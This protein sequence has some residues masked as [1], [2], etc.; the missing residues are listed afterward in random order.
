MSGSAGLELTSLPLEERNRVFYSSGTTEQ[1]RSR[2]FHNAASLAIYE[3]S[4]LPW[5]RKHLL[6]D[7]SRAD[8]LFLTPPPE[9][10]P[11][12]SL[13]HMFEAVK[14]ELGS[15]DSVFCGMAL[16]D[17]AWELDWELELLQD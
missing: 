13:V 3:A 12:S 15:E 9:Q 11:N 1:R 8:F 6:A 17:G 14:R 2:H 16:D 5:F 10:A 7:T 4:L